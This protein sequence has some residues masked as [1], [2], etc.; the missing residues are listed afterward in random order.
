M[1]S[2]F[3]TLV[4]LTSIANNQV[5]VDNM[6]INLRRIVCSKNVILEVIR[7]EMVKS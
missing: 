5:T 7:I 3:W 1:K 6:Q 2:W 4:C